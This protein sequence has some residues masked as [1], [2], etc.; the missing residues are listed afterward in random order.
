MIS[1]NKLTRVVGNQIIWDYDVVLFENL[2]KDEDVKKVFDDKDCR[3][4]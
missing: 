2:E 3:W 4:S 1:Y